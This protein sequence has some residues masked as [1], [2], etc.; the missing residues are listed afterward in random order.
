METTVTP[1]IRISDESYRRLQEWAEPFEDT[2]DSALR[3]VLDAAS[4]PK[5]GVIPELPVQA[6]PTPTPDTSDAPKG[7]AMTP[8]SAFYPRIMVALREMSGRATKAEVTRRIGTG[9]G[10]R[11]TTVDWEPVATGEPRWE[12]KVAWARNRL[13]ELGLIRRGSPR[14][15]WELTDE[16]MK[17]AEEEDWPSGWPLPD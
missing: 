5:L 2:V 8:E 11:L 13:C 6:R 10:S 12:N 9:L 15:I 7:E 1:V 4:A 14:G 17:M 16:G 3:K